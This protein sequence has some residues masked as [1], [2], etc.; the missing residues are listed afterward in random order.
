MNIID[1]TDNQDLL[2]LFI[3]DKSPYLLKK[4]ISKLDSDGLQILSRNR[5]PEI[6]QLAQNRKSN[7][8]L[9]KFK[10]GAKEG[11]KII[12][13]DDEF[14]TAGDKNN[15]L[16]DNSYMTPAGFGMNSQNSPAT[17]MNSM[18]LKINQFVSKAEMLQKEGGIGGGEGSALTAADTSTPTFGYSNS[19][20]KKIKD[21]L[22]FKSEDG[23]E[24]IL[25]IV[26]SV[27]EE[28]FGGE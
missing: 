7:V 17:I 5:N 1:R 16:P 4:L 11:D 8:D 12:N 26:K 20:K 6:R 13:S 27:G 22:Q 23:V 9:E 19:I 18:V 15:E 25:N 14:A 24:G 28:F 10:K 21:N 2:H 3:A